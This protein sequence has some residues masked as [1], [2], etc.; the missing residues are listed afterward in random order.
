MKKKI[1]LSNL[2]AI[3]IILA[4][5]SSIK[6]QTDIFDVE[7]NVDMTSAENFDPDY[8]VIYLTGSM[9][10]W[11]EPGTQVDD[12]LMTRVG[13]SMIWT[14]TSQL[15]A[16]EHQYKY[17]KNAGWMNGEWGGEPNRVIQVSADMITNDEW[18]IMPNGNFYDVTFNVDMSLVPNF[19]PDADV[20]YI[21]G[22]Y[23]NWPMPGSMPD[24]QLMNRI[25]GTM[26]WTK[27]LN[28]QEGSH[29]Y[30]YFINYGWDRGEWTDLRSRALQ[31]NEPTVFDD[32]WA[33]CFPASLPVNE[34][35]DNQPAGY[36]PDCWYI[37]GIGDFDGLVA[38]GIASSMPNSL[39]LYHGPQSQTLLIS[40]Y[41]DEDLANLQISF[42]AVRSYYNQESLPLV[43]GVMTDQNDPSSFQ[44]LTTFN[45]DNQPNQAW[46]YFNFYFE[47]YAGS[48]NYIA[49]KGLSNDPDG[50][51]EAYIDDIVIDFIP[52]CPPPYLLSASNIGLTEAQ[53]GW[54]ERGTAA[55]WDLILGLQ[56]FNPASEGTLIQNLTEQSYLA[57]GLDHSTHYDFYVR[58]I[59]G[60]EPS[61][62]S[63]PFTFTTEC[64][65]EELTITYPT[66]NLVFDISSGN[67]VHFSF[68]FRG[69][70]DFYVQ[71]TLF[72]ENDEYITYLAQ[73]YLESSAT[74][75]HD[76]QLPVTICNGNYYYRVSYW[77]DQ[78]QTL[79]GYNSPVFS[80]INNTTN[81]EIMT[82][83]FW[84][85]FVTG[86]ICEIGWNSSTDENVAIHYSLNNGTDWE[87]I[88]LD[89]TSAC[90]YCFD[91]INKFDWLVPT[92]ILGLF[93]ECKIKISFADNPDFYTISN[94]FTITSETQVWFLEPQSGQV[95][96]PGDNITASVET[97]H[98][99]WTDF[100]IVD[101]FENMHWISS[102]NL[103]AGI[104]QFQFSTSGFNPGY[105]YKILLYYNYT[106]QW[107]Y[108]EPFAILEEIPACHPAV[109]LHTSEI[110]ASSAILNWNAWVGDPLWNIEY[111]ITGFTPGNGTQINNYEFNF[112]QINNLI[113]GVSYDFYVQAVCDASTTSTWSAPLTFYTLPAATLFANAGPNGS[114]QPSG[115]VYVILGE[116][117]TFTITPD[118]GYEI[119]DVLVDGV[120]VGALSTYTFGNVTVNHT[121]EASF[122]IL[123]YSINASAGTG[124]SISP[125]GNV[126][127]NYGQNQ[128]FSITPDTGY[129]IADVLV[130]GVSVGALS[131]YT[132]G[133]VTANHTIEASFSILTYSINASAG[134]GGSISPSGNLSVNYGQNLTFSITPATGY[135]IADVLV[136]GVSVGALS[137]YTFGNVTAN[138]TIDASFSILTYSINA[139]AGTGG[140]ISPSGNVNVNYG[141][142][143]TFSIT[144]ATG[145]EI[146]DVLV[147]GVSVGAL[148]TYTFGNVTANHT[149]EASFSILTYSINASAGTGGSISPYGNV[150]VNYGSN[151]TFSITP[152]TG[153]EI[154]DVLVDGVSVG[155]LSTYTFGNVT[156][157]HTI[158]ASF[159]ILPYSINAS[160]GTGGSISPEG[161]IIL[162]YGGNQLFSF[163]PDE[164]YIISSVWVDG[165][166]LGFMEN[167]TFESVSENHTIHVDFDLMIGYYNTPGNS[168]IVKLYPNPAHDQLT[169]NVQD[170]TG[171]KHEMSFKLFNLNGSILLEGIINDDTHSLNVSKLHP[172]LYQLMVYKNQMPAK[173]MKVVIY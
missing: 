99:S 62:W 23:Y 128:T 17:F 106:M 118:T 74:I 93:T 145:Y 170:N 95:V 50:W 35:F 54:V 11:A 121:I 148:S 59:C 162:T 161:T 47:D 68:T 12:Q 108:S 25:D 123:T 79:H 96:Y 142:N 137:T 29:L 78:T 10:G 109:N 72:N 66:D 20:V 87:E 3:I 28:L 19:N 98:E 9:L 70:A 169:I 51:Y 92:S 155:A 13:T 97:I 36:K 14:K 63:I 82:P 40:P 34:N 8:D 49:F 158:E 46:H 80:I 75:D 22:S 65:G 151:L 171:I 173:T 125:S 6:A 18:G 141:Q 147:D 48:A 156:A 81:L 61:D 104:N 122:S 167:Y 115:I 150:N 172:G 86:E 94:L 91:G 83:N 114:I 119:A 159:S 154:A 136:D 105:N 103:I 33:N 85:V 117:Q 16:G 164:G 144:P 7:F 149:I 43:V 38:D 168:L 102:S 31:I 135:E 53:L 130:D 143:L 15:A 129:E 89:Y 52:A 127:V 163:I 71:T 37:N 153:Y 134:T 140:S 160:A 165:D 157:N 101:P 112:I 166:S 64:F 56:G 88:V 44:P 41:L 132:F 21:T 110:G 24:E 113:P 42:R 60:T 2:L 133:N 152:A 111:G 90:G 120:S 58:S 76:F 57:G 45:L 124:G 131:T 139:S 126:N 27:T 55:E 32:Y 116:S 69:C 5:L 67:P 39:R 107:I 1:P 146:A 4:S 77:N 100:Y 26:I 84:N 30:K 138:H 73:D